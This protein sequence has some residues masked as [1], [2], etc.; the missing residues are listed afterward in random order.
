[1]LPPKAQPPKSVSSDNPRIFAMRFGEFFKTS[2]VV[3]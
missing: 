2:L 1:M 3:K